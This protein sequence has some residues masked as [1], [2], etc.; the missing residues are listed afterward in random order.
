MCGQCHTHWR[1]TGLKSGNVRL[2]RLTYL[3]KQKFLGLMKN[4]SIFHYVI[5]LKQQVHLHPHIPTTFIWA[6]WVDLSIWSP[7][8]QKNHRNDNFQWFWSKVIHYMLG[9][10]W[11]ENLQLSVIWILG[12]SFCVNKNISIPLNIGNKFGTNFILKL[13]FE[14]G[15]NFIFLKS[16]SVLRPFF[17]LF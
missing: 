9:K 13:E 12:S 4:M 15:F 8:S 14:R 17:Y 7:I 2:S 5:F 3:V 1:Q 11:T 10:L 6:R 16:Y